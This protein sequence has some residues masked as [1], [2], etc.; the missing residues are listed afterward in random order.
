MNAG[1]TGNTAHQPLIACLQTTDRSDA[2]VD[3][4]SRID[5]TDQRS[6]FDASALSATP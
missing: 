5:W 1:G 3:E 4:V 6:V 2:M